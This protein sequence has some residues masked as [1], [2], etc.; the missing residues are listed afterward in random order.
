MASFIGLPGNFPISAYYKGD[1][2]FQFAFTSGG[3]P[4]VLTGASASFVIYEKNG[5]AALT[6]SG[7]SGLTINGAAGTIDLAITNAQIVALATQEYNYEFILTLSGG[8]VWPVLDGTFNVSEDGQASYSGDSVTVALDGNTITL[9]ITPAAVSSSRLIPS[10]GTSGQVLAKSSNTDYAVTW[11]SVA[12]T[13]DMTKAVYDTDDDGK[14][15]AVED[16]VS[17][18]KVIVS[19]AGSTVGT[20]QQINLI[21][22]SNVT[23]TVSDN[24]GS[25]RVDVTIAASGGGGGGD[26]L[27]ATYD[28]ANIAQ[29]VVGT[30]ATQNLTNKTLSSFT[31]NITA[32]AVHL[33][34]RNES[35]GTLTAGTP[36]YVSGYS[37]G[38]N[39]ILV[40]AADASAAATMPCIGLVVSSISNN[41]TGEVVE[42]GRVEN[43]NTSSFSAGDILYVSETTGALT[44]TKP[45]GSALVQEVGQVLRSHATLGVIEVALRPA[46]YTTGFIAT[47]LDDVDAA[48]ARTTLGVDAAGTDNSTPVTLA[49]SLDYLTISGQQITRGAIDLA[50]DVTGNLPVTNLNG[51]TSAS[52]STF[53]RGDGTWATPAGGGSLN[54]GDTLS[55]GLTFPNTGLHILDTNATHD[56]ILSPGSNLTADRT[57][58]ITTG[59]ANRTL[60]ISAADVT[61][62]S[63]GASILDDADAGTVRTTIGAAASSHTHTYADITSGTIPGGTIATVE[64]AG[65]FRI[66]YAS[67][68]TAITVDNGAAQTKVESDNSAAYA[69]LDNTSATLG[70]SNTAG[71]DLLF[72]DT[73]LQIRDYRAGASAVGMEYN[74]DYS[75]NYSARSLT[76]KGYVDTQVAT[77]IADGATLS[78][79]LTFP[80]TGLHILDTNASHDL[81]IAPGSDLSADRTLTITTGDADRTLTISGSTTLGGGSHSGTNTGDVSLSGTP[82]YIT[83]SGQTITVAQVDLAA[84]VTGTLPAANGGTGLNALGS[85]LQQLRVNAGGTALEYFTPS[86]GG[87]SVSTD[88]IW[89]AKGDLAVGTGADTAAKLTVG[90][91]GHILYADSATSSGLR[92][93]PSVI[94]PSQITSDQDDYNPTGWATATIVRLDGD[95]GF[96]AI[97]SF[98][99]GYSGEVKTLVNIGSYP[100]YFP[101]EHPDGTAANRISAEKDIILFPKK[102]L[103]MYYDGTAA[104]WRIITLDADKND[105]RSVFYS[106][107]AGSTTAGDYPDFTLL[108]IN[109]GT[110]TGTSAATASLP[111][112][113][114]LSTAA[115]TNGGGTFY[116][117]KTQV[118]FSYFSS[119]HIFSDFLFYLPALSDGTETY[120]IGLQILNFPTTS[121]IYDN[122]SIGVRYTHGT[123]SGKFQGYSKDN[124]GSE[125]TVDLG[126]T[127][128]ANTLYKVRIEVDKGNTEARFYIDNTYCG[129]V[130]SN[131]PTGTAAGTRAILLKTA[132]TT[133]R[134]LNMAAMSAGAIYP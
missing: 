28:P 70:F 110:V 134:T 49:G 64:A 41:A 27:A 101:G 12:G 29:Q 106:W 85:A 90:T 112:A 123:N 103:Q 104:R 72:S 82:D 44:A 71:G 124:A 48:T 118:H 109:S 69:I 38:Q 33:E 86:G 89:D 8:S 88:T 13:G 21:E 22:G 23:L 98:A 1:F 96:R 20:R 126:V 4:Y 15:D 63:F 17:T 121:N 94:S 78:T 9:T 75:A 3:S 91:N 62:S 5:T 113:N 119:A 60:D 39:R 100:I 6:L 108:A 115:T 114:V 74:A 34:V 59:D 16:N 76:D 80:N 87:G 66:N 107:S 55:T 37:V 10:G 102:S 84:D 128:A 24:A 30:T 79:G 25:D 111:A 97:T 120:Q 81:I 93:G 53:W 133:A 42:N 50:T 2:A 11:Q 32:D 45:T 40:S 58:T 131:M 99:A 61:I 43:V 125:S 92:W 14:V 57:L 54:D 19:K 46:S 51:G 65:V 83:I 68:D 73:T 36:V 116:F 26:M 67:G 52:A 18:Q 105:F 56:L 117:S 130:T 127:V 47:L 132:G 122:N 31:N 129:R 7:G 95:S 77:K 35:G